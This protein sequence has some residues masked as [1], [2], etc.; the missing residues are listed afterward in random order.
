MRQALPK[1]VLVGAA[2]GPA[3]L[4]GRALRLL[5][6]LGR[7]DMERATVLPVAAFA[8]A[9]G[10]AAALPLLALRLDPARRA[11]L[12]LAVASVTVVLYAAELALGVHTEAAQNRLTE[13]LRAAEAMGRPGAPA[14]AAIEPVRLVWA[15]PASAPS[16]LDV[17]G[18][19]TLPLA[20]RAMSRLVF[21][22][23]ELEGDWRA[24]DTDEHGFLNPVGLWSRAPVSLAAVG[25]SFTAGSCVAADSSMV[26]G[27]RR[28]FPDVAN[29]GVPGS[30]PLLI[31]GLVREYLPALRPRE[32]LWCHFE[33]N[34]WVDL[35]REKGHPL[36]RR[37]LEDG[38]RQGLMEKQPAIDRALDG[39]L[40]RSHRPAAL[41]LRR[42]KGLSARDVLALR[43]LRA[44][45]GLVLS[46]PLG[47]VPTE[48]EYALFA[49]VL[50]RAQRT[51]AAWGGTLRFVYLPAGE[52]R[53]HVSRAADSAA[54][55]AVRARTLS[56]VRGLSIPVIDVAAAWATRPDAQA[57]FACPDCHYT[58]AGYQFAADTVLSAL[59]AAVDP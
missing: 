35:R 10:I 12:A 53:W 49:T 8:A 51:V 48:E 55:A 5:V 7:H 22:R 45:L 50:E 54:A 1:L 15:R 28:R 14:Y 26:A 30:G 36:L 18:V 4:L 9:L 6:D 25:D 19:P 59:P 46:D 47:H 38:F 33:G 34:D 43:G 23:D 29:L 3:L 2:A 21:C 52:P 17:G 40:E 24:Y 41:K 27:L 37:Y 42:R 20:A 32:V 57:L 11:N 56:L 31:L 13:R 16:A 39:Y 58:P 44:R